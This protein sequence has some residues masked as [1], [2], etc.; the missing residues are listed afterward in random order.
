MKEIY[1][2]LILL[3]LVLFIGFGTLYAYIQG[4]NQDKRFIADYQSYQSSLAQL[5]EE[6]YDEAKEQL[7]KLHNDYPDQANITRNLGLVYAIKGDM[8][9]AAI[10]YQKAV[11]QRPYIIQDQMFSLQ[12]AEVLINIEEYEAAKQYLEYL[13]TTIGVPE[14]YIGH[15]DE[16]LAYIETIK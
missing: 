11:D 12:F 3:G 9:K 4:K 5:Q 1:R 15:V 8:E 7:I 10:Y 14:E 2:K 16:L 13:K 6:K